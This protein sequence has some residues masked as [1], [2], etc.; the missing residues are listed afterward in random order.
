MT[1]ATNP[2]D[3]FLPITRAWFAQTLGRPPPPPPQ[4]QGWPAIQ[5]GEHT[6]IL[7]PTGSG[8]TLSAFLW[9]I[10]GL[11]RKR[12]RRRGEERATQNPLSL[13]RSPFY[14]VDFHPYNGIVR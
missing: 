3:A 13:L 6:L 11:S 10:D 5:R 12:E 2:L 7:A 14:S 1:T 9:G 4:Q 8:K